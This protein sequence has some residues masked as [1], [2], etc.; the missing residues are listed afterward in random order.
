LF[1]NVH[2]N[3]VPRTEFVIT[4]RIGHSVAVIWCLGRRGGQANDR[5]RDYT[6]SV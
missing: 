4:N 3:D 5:E 2:S 1:E 6:Q